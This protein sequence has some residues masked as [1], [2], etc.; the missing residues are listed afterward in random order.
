MQAESSLANCTKLDAAVLLRSPYSYDSFSFVC[1][2]EGN[3]V[4]VPASGFVRLTWLPPFPLGEVLVGA[5]L[6]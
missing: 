3:I 6:R 2:G 4:P 5:R 1:M